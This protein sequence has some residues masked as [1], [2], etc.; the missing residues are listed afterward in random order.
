VRAVG[1]R[2]DEVA[3]SKLRT[4]QDDAGDREEFKA[5][6]PFLELT[7]RR[8]RHLDWDPNKDTSLEEFLNADDDD[9]LDAE[10]GS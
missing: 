3:Y 8:E 9:G 1:R 5:E 10:Y 6:N 7:N 4:Q 2:K